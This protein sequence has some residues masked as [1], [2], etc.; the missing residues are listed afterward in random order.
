MVSIVF[1]QATTVTWRWTLEDLSKYV[2][3]KEVEAATFHYLATIRLKQDAF[4]S[5]WLFD[6]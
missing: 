3:E 4:S 6:L 1:I 5:T 2:V